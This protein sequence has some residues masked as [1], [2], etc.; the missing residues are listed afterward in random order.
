MQEINLWAEKYRPSN[1]DD[2]VLPQ[3]IKDQFKRFVEDGDIPSLLLSGPAGTGK[4]TLAKALCNELGCDYIII[5]GSDESG[6]DTLRTK[7]KNFAA[8]VSLSMEANHKVVIID[9]ADY[10]SPTAQPALRGMIDEFAK[11]CRIIFTCNFKHRIIDPLQSRCSTIDFVFGKD[12]IP[13]LQAAFFQRV[14]QILESE[15]VEY[16]QKVLARYVQIRYPDFRKTLNELQRYAVSGAV[17]SGILTTMDDGDFEQLVQ[18]MKDKKFTD[19]RKWIGENPSF[20]AV[21]LF[22]KLY[23]KAYKYLKP[24]AIPEVIIILANYQY[25]AAFVASQEI[26]AM[27]CLTEIMVVAEWQ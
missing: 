1:I 19:I 8:T 9:E 5:N 17:D 15:G 26:N 2:C 13:R 11:N 22:Q 14:V 27:A 12:D 6:I 4:T 25:K 16:D 24:Q 3:S 10:L 7:V 21:S 18:M 23:D 20:D